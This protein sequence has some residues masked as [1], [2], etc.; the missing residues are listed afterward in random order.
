MLKVLYFYLHE[1]KT[2]RHTINI[3]LK[4][5]LDEGTNYIYPMLNISKLKKKKTYNTNIPNIQIFMLKM[6]LLEN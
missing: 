2:K 5:N 4:H 1:T 3:F 6:I